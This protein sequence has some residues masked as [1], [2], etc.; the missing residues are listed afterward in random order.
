MGM[1][2]TS[3]TNSARWH[4]P[5]QVP[6][7]KGDIFS[8]ACEMAADM[9]GWTVTET[10]EA[11]LRIVATKQNG[12]LGGTSTITVAVDGPADIPN[13]STHCRSESSGALLSRDKGNVAEFI[14]KFWMR[15]S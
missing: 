13:S 10:D 2:E 9:P 14:Q 15:V 11:A 8:A 7:E 12:F 3:D 6:R 4:K 5:V 1:F